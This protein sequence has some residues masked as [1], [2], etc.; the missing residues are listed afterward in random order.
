M[1]KTTL[2]IIAALFALI[3]SN[4]AIAGRGHY[5]DRGHNG[6]NYGGH[7]NRGRG[8]GHY[9]GAVLG[10]L[11]VGG[12]I[13]SSLN[14]SYNRRPVYVNTYPVNVIT[15]SNFLLKSNGDCFLITNGSNG[16]QILS[17]VPGS[18]CR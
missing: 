7:G 5:N 18:N 2:I 3:S 8:G 11:I 12:I 10:G 4:S 13:G 1:K 14:A 9:P 15:G 16:N 6:H 17:S